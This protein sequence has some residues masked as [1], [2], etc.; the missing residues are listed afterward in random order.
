[1]AIWSRNSLSQPN[2]GELDH[3]F[4]RSHAPDIFGLGPYGN[5]RTS[6]SVA[7]VQRRVIRIKICGAVASNR[8]RHE[9]N[10]GQ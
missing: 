3:V 8:H 6:S 9:D 2:S 1:M 10:Q 4:N 7:N 5:V